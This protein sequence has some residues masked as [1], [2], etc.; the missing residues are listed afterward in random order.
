MKLEKWACRFHLQQLTH[1]LVSRLLQ[2][3][4][5]LGSKFQFWLITIR[6]GL[7]KII[8]FYQIF[9]HVFYSYISLKRY[10]Q[11]VANPDSTLTWVNIFLYCPPKQLVQGKYRSKCLEILAILQ[12]G[13]P[14]KAHIFELQMLQRCSFLVIFSI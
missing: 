3:T 5:N 12:N 7:F 13:V 2:L 11:H 14:F 10:V 4:D 8:P 1:D 9:R 6:N